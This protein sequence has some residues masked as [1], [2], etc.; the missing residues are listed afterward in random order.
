MTYFMVHGCGSNSDADDGIGL[1]WI[2]A[3]S[4]YLPRRVGQDGGGH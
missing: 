2:H 4:G 1:F 3:L